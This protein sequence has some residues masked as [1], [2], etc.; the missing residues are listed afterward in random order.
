[1]ERC[2]TTSFIGKTEDVPETETNN[3]L[4]GSWTI[5]MD[6]IQNKV[7]NE[8]ENVSPEK[9]DRILQD[10]EQF[11]SYLGDKVALG[12]KMGLGEEQLAKTAEVVAGYL[13]KKNNHV[14][15]RRIFFKNCGALEIKSSNML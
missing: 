12:E 11:K 15:P 2:L 7:Q 5:M 4:K 13:S 14:M 10:F 9:K 8:M 6:N 3:Y 1:M